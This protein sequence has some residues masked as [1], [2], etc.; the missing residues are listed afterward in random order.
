VSSRCWN[1]ACCPTCFLSV[2]V[3]R[4]DLQFGTW[5]NPSFQWHYRFCPTALGSR[6]G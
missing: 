5:T 1:R 2:S 4:N 3:T 6:S